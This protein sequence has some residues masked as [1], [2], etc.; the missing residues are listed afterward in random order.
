MNIV[1]NILIAGLIARTL[2]DLATLARSSLATDALYVILYG[3]LAGAIL[4]DNA[5]SIFGYATLIAA[6]GWAVHGVLRL[7][8]KSAAG[9]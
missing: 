9:T 7:R 3:G 5:H 4:F 2:L 1:V 6:L 8:K